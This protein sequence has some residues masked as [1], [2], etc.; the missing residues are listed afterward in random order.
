MSIKNVKASARPG[1]HD[2]RL[3]FPGDVIGAELALQSGRIAQLAG[4]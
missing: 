2:A 4:W 3:G 1:C